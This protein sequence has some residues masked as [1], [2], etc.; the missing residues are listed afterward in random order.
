MNVKTYFIDLIWCRASA[1][2][3]E[4]GLDVKDYKERAN[5]QCIVITHTPIKHLNWDSNPV[6][7]KDESTRISDMYTHLLDGVKDLR[8]RFLPSK[9]EK[10]EVLKQMR[11]DEKNGKKPSDAFDTTSK[12][13]NDLMKLAEASSESDSSSTTA[14]KNAEVTKN[15]EEVKPPSSSKHKALS[16][17][18]SY[19]GE[20]FGI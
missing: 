13:I 15:V 3:L 2:Y 17:V 20:D 18:A 16:V 10:Y 4:I 14:N 1:L 11:E 8:Y 12:E 7:S 9:D 19:P 5:K 6:R